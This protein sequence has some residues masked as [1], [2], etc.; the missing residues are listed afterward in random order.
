MVYSQSGLGGRVRCLLSLLVSLPVGVALE[1]VVNRLTSAVMWLAKNSFSWS[2]SVV[3]LKFKAIA[4]VSFVV[5]N[6]HTSA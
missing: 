3:E 1:G 6:S 2:A 5:G 4:G